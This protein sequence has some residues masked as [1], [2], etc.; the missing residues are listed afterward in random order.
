[1]TF[2]FLLEGG[3]PSTMACVPAE[4]PPV[5]LSDQNKMQLVAPFVYLLSWPSTPGFP[6]TIVRITRISSS[7]HLAPTTLGILT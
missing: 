2:Y 1:M 3:E 7:Y 4:A 6:S 5:L